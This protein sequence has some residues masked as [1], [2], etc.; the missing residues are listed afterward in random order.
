[1]PTRTRPWVTFLL[2]G[3]NLAVFLVEFSLGGPEL[4]AFIYAFGVI[5]AEFNVVSAVTAMFLHGGWMHLAGNMMSL[6]IFGDNVED[7]MGHGRF[8]LFY[9]IAGILGSAAQTA[10]MPASPVP[11][12]GAS[13]AIAAVMGAYFVLFPYSR[14][15]V[16][17]FLVFYI[18]VV[19]VPAVLFLAFWFLMQL[20]SGVGQLAGIPGGHVGFWAHIG[21]FA[22]GVAGVWFFRRPERQRVEWWG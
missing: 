3:I 19:E 18:D 13:G 22:C 17:V 4:E 7:R 20:L 12:V 11:L 6:W 16:L 2:I 14:I 9:L 1:M 10:A 21:G 15:L 8:L 5:P